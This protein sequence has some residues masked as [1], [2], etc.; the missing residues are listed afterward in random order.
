MEVASNDAED[1][2][3]ELNGVGAQW[4]LPFSFIIGAAAQPKRNFL[5]SMA[6]LRVWNVARTATEIAANMNVASPDDDNFNL[7]AAWN[8]TEG[9]GNNIADSAYGVYPLTAN[10]DLSWSSDALPF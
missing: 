8:F 6:Y 5:G 3:I 7:L 4:D 2:A 1:H 10:S 9:S